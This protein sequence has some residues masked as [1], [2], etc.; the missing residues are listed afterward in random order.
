[1]KG[2]SLLSFRFV[3]LRRVVV[4]GS[5]LIWFA[6]WLLGMD[7]G[8]N[9]IFDVS[10]LDRGTWASRERSRR[11]EGVELSFSRLV[12]VGASDPEDRKR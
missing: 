4:F 2:W 5:V 1:M 9:D 8:F 10:L 3:S 7:I 11:E 12:Y 6:L